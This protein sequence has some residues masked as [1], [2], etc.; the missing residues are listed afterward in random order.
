M[1]LNMQLLLLLPII[2]SAINTSTAWRTFLRGRN[3]YGNLGHPTLSSKTY[4]LPEEKW[5]TQYLDHF[6]PTDARVWEQVLYTRKD[7]IIFVSSLN[8]ISFC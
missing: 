1:H 3:K 2:L 7:F 4:M 5:F 8:F 6:N